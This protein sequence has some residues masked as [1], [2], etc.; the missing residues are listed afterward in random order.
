MAG[1]E[2]ERT[3]LVAKLAAFAAY[4]WLLRVTTPA[5]VGTYA[6]VNPLVAVGLAWAVGDEP[7][8]PRT[9]AAAAL[10][11]CAVLLVREPSTG[12]ER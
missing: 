7:A 3:E 10:V 4:T 2:N 11:V 1:A 9:A 6:F 12:G 5:A 8:S